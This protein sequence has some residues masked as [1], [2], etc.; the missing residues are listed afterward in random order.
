MNIKN[1]FTFLLFGVSCLFFAPEKCRAM[2][3]EEIQSSFS[4]QHTVTVHNP[5]YPEY[6]D[7]A[8]IELPNGGMVSFAAKGSIGKVIRKAMKSNLIDNPL[9]LSHSGLLLL[10][11]PQHVFKTVQESS[12]IADRAREAMLN[13]LLKYHKREI[14]M[15]DFKGLAPFVL[16]A[17]GTAEQAL[18][19]IYPH[20]QIS[21]FK[22]SLTEYEGNVYLRQIM[23]DIPTDFT[24]DFIQTYI[25]KSY[26]TLGTLD[27]LLKA[28]TGS[29]KQE[30]IQNVFCSELCGIFYRQVINEIVLTDE[31][32][33]SIHALMNERLRS[34]ANVSNIIP[35]QFGSGAGADDLLNT[36]ATPEII[37]KDYFNHREDDAKFQCCRLF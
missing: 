28:V 34:Y 31:R 24:G 37:L 30:R 9:G 7:R 32:Y 10:D 5:C 4:S 27:E 21:P 18:G 8:Q 3:D 36:L 15:V 20:V 35:E 12:Q 13:G 23:C 19:F 17:N 1:M 2:I 33:S 6:S 11:N 16:E 29:N 25:G 22:K 26:E 14:A